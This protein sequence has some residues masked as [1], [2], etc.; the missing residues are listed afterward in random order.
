[1]R[2]VD[3][4]ESRGLFGRK[5]GKD[6]F[7]NDN[8]ETIVFQ[9]VQ[10]YPQ[11]KNPA[12]QTAQA[13]DRFATFLQDEYET[14]I[15]WVNTRSQVA[16]AFAI[17]QFSDQSGGTRLW[18][19]WYNEIPANP[20]GTWQN[21]QVPPR[22]QLNIPAANKARSGLSPQ[23][24]I[25][26]DKES[27]LTVPSIVDRIAP[28]LSEELRQGIAQVA[29]GKLPAVFANQ[30]EN[31]TAIR[32]NLGEIIQPIALKAGLVQGDADA[33]AT[34][35]LGTS[36]AECKVVWPQGKIHNLIDSYFIGPNGQTLGISSKGDRGAN[37]SV[38]NI[39]KAIED[40]QKKNPKLVDKHKAAIRFIRVIS[41][42]SAKEGPVALALVLG[43]IDI[44][45][46]EDIMMLVRQPV[47]KLPGSLKHLRY[48]LKEYNADVNNPNYNVGYHLLS[49]L[50]KQCCDVI[51]QDKKF[52]AACVDFL[53]QSNIIQ[54]YTDAKVAGVDTQITG[55][56]SVYPPN[57]S[58]SVVLTSA[59]GYSASEI[60]GRFTFD[61]KKAGG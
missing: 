7:V 43:I 1:M 51:N 8:G 58:G 50:A 6:Q 10:M 52:S 61:Y 26:T 49:S 11:K 54:V 33:A 45:Y 25:K 15:E 40:A 41:E 18:G 36:F 9:G 60:K 46:Y 48:L 39:F 59:K 57:F 38:Q 28:G 30:K 22:W 2:I 32:D 4:V 3:I 23:D 53:N 44:D 34:E 56:R 21:N 27:F 24:L 14:E 55:F 5:I 35:V 19:R 29:A 17:A 20:V 47:K 31:F 12:Q 37:A 13:L 42:T 16:K